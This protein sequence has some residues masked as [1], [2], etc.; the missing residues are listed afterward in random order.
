MRF[1]LFPKYLNCLG[2]RL[3]IDTGRAFHK[4]GTAMENAFDPVVL[5]FVRGTKNL[6]ESQRY[7]GCLLEFEKL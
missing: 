1:R 5:V 2:I 7:M 4:A 6:F 3:R